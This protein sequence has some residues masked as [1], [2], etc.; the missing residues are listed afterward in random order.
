MV[1][2]DYAMRGV[3]LE[4][5]ILTDVLLAGFDT[6]LDTPPISHRQAPGFPHSSD[7]T[8]ADQ[9]VV[10]FQYVLRRWLHIGG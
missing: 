3:H 7:A 1:Y 10:G 9:A 4:A 5:E 2:C 8:V 6:R